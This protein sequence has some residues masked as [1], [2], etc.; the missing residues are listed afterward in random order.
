VERKNPGTWHCGRSMMLN[1]TEIFKHDSKTLQLPIRGFLKGRYL[2]ILPWQ[3]L[4][5]GSNRWAISM[6]IV[7]LDF[8]G[9]WPANNARPLLFTSTQR[10][11]TAEAGP[12]SMCAG[13]SSAAREFIPVFGGQPQTCE[14]SGGPQSLRNTRGNSHLTTHCI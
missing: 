1:E 14:W 13:H 9:I 3:L 2:Y 6:Q 5:H 8:L 7:H 10:L 4:L 12:W 11:C